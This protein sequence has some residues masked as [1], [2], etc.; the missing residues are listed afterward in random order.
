MSQRLEY[1]HKGK[2]GLDEIAEYHLFEN[3]KGDKFEIRIAE[4]DKFVMQNWQ[5][6]G[7]APYFIAGFYSL[8][9]ELAE[10]NE[11]LFFYCGNGYDACNVTKWIDKMEEVGV[12]FPDDKPVFEIIARLIADYTLNESQRGIQ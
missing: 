1:I 7:L 2:V 3:D 6:Y 11:V 5:E 12:K 9:W 4:I 8:G 10:I